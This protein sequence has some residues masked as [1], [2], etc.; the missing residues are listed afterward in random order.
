[1]MG[2]SGVDGVGI[3]VTLGP[4]FPHDSYRHP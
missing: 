1:V 3:Y 4:V 2:T